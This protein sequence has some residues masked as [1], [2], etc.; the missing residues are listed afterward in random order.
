[1]SVLSLFAAIQTVSRILL[2]VCY[3]LHDP[4]L[5]EIR[6]GVVAELGGEIPHGIT[7]VAAGKGIA[8]GG[9]DVLDEV[10]HRPRLVVCGG[11]RNLH[12]GSRLGAEDAGG[13]PELADSPHEL[14]ACRIEARLAKIGPKRPLPLHPAGKLAPHLDIAEVVS[15][16]RKLEA[17]PVARAF[18]RRARPRSGEDTSANPP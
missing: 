10:R 7:E 6:S 14:A 15:A 1:M 5:V 9:G 17:P 18:G 2:A 11:E 12:D 16:A 13:G 3:S 4:P 8:A